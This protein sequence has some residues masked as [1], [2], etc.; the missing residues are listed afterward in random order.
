METLE[1]LRRRLRSASELHEVVGTM[2][3]LSAVNVR[4]YQRALGGVDG[5]ARTVSLGMQ[6]VLRDRPTVPATPEG[7]QGG[8]IVVVF[9]S[10]QGLCG[11]VNR[12]VAELTQD[13]FAPVRL[14]PRDPWVVAVGQRV[15]HELERLDMPP[16]ETFRHPS[17]PEAVSAHVQ[18]LLVHVDDWRRRQQADHILLVHARPLQQRTTAYDVRVWP[19]W[20]LDTEWLD[21]HAA[22][23]WPTRILPT[24][25]PDWRTAFEGLVRQHLFLTLFRAAVSSLAAIEASRLASM[26]AA[27]SNIEDRIE[28][29]E[30]RYHQHRQTAITEE[31]LDVTS[32]FE[33]LRTGGPHPQGAPTH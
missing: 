13:R 12:H 21:E 20:P 2:K 31:L 19:L 29:L 17:T 32:G 1:S 22:R 9:G 28:E 24:T 3:S 30:R 6:I 15:A 11:P 14:E 25:Y 33:A 16:E 27:E 26:Q 8:R 23:P 18:D 7:A 4:R 5:Y 10:D